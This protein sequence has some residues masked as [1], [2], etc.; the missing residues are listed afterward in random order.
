MARQPELDEL[1]GD[2][3]KWADRIGR[4][5]EGMDF[6]AFAA[7][8]KTQDAVIRCLEVIGEASSRILKIA[9]RL[10]EEHPELQL[11]QAYRARNRTA[12]GYGSVSLES[13]W[14]SAIDA[15]PRMADAARWVLHRQGGS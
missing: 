8:L 2:I 7:D 12:H 3:A 10:Q 13:I 1:L 6:E 14:G 15:A 9:P 4:Y 11:R 5:V